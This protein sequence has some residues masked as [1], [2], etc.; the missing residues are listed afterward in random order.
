MLLTCLQVTIE[1]GTDKHC[2]EVTWKNAKHLAT[3]KADVVDMTFEIIAT[4]HGEENG[5]LHTFRSVPS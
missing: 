2:L 1:Q 3:L 5:T 4:L